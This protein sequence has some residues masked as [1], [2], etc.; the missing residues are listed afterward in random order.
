MFSQ[1]MDPARG[2]SGVGGTVLIPMRF[3]W[4]YGG[5]SVFLTGSFTGCVF[6]LLK[7]SSFRLVYVCLFPFLLVYLM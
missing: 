7:C 3:V 5:R 4:P 1:S 6:C 2:A